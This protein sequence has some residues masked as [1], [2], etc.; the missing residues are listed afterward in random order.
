MVVEFVDGAL[1]CKKSAK[2]TSW[3]PGAKLLKT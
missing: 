2:G 1:V 3:E